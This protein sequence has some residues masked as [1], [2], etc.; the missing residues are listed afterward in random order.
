M[1]ADSRSAVSAV[2][3]DVC[4]WPGRQW[5]EEPSR[6]P[7]SASFVCQA[8]SD[9]L[10]LFSP[11]TT[12]LPLFEPGRKGQDP[13]PKPSFDLPNGEKLFTREEFAKFRNKLA[14]L[15][16]FFLAKS[17]P[18]SANEINLARPADKRHTFTEGLGAFPFHLNPEKT[19]DL[20]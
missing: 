10:L 17:H 19:E 13:Y 8:F 6:F 4:T 18:N 12:I 16:S 1:A 11:V 15:Q 3:G 2:G 9:L 14:H 7:W 5:D 20:P